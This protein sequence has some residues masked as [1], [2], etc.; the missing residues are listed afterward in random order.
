MSSTITQVA[1]NIYVNV[2]F[3]HDPS[4][5]HSTIAEYRV[6][7][8]IPIL[9]K[10]DDYYCSVIRFDIPLDEVPLFIMPIDTND[11]TNPIPR[12]P[13]KTPFIIGISTGGVDYPENIIY[14]SETGFT[15]PIQNQPVQ[16]ITPYYY[17]FEYQNLITSINAALQKAFVASGLGGSAPYFYLDTSSEQI[18]LVADLA[19]FA[20]VATGSLPG[21][22]QT[23][24]PVPT[25]TIFMNSAL[26]IYLS[27]FPVHFVG[28]NANGKNYVFDLVRFGI[29]NNIPPFSG[30]ATQRLFSQEY[31]VLQIWSSLRKILITTNSIPIV[32][33]YTPTNNSGISSTF[34]IISD[35]TPQLELPGQARS[36]AY[37]VPTSQYRLVD[38]KSS[39]QLNTI[40]LKI[41]WQDRAE[42]IYPLLISRFQQASIKLG[43]FK[44]SLY[45]GDPS[46]LKK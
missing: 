16:V 37:Y 28:F 2:I 13:D 3:G 30:A 9:D 12:N 18:K 24:L 26:E 4:L 33:E 22:P 44:K 15:A 10:C 40:D 42:N 20:P 11:V 31:S 32:S 6:T 41:Y 46:L 27:A 19:T 45:K 21:P 14:M 17:V 23:L 5:Q 29:D 36:I 38:L 34:P 39:E 7:K 1:D 35:F 25:A 43:F 8:T